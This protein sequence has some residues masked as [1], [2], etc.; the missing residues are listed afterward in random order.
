MVTAFAPKRV[1]L[2]IEAC[3]VMKTTAE[4][5]RQKGQEEARLRKLAGPTVEFLGWPDEV[6]R[7]RTP[8]AG[9]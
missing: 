3:N 7:D 2:A 4:D 9:P 8:G 1:D 5:H 6:V